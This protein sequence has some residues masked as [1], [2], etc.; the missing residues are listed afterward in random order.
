MAGAKKMDID[1]LKAQRDQL[2][3]EAEI[4]NY[5]AELIEASLRRMRAQR[6]FTEER[7]KLRS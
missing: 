6:E 4:A 2:A 7:A 5:R 1:E 3:V